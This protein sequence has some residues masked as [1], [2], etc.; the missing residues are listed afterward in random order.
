MQKV[1][2]L[3]EANAY[4]PCQVANLENGNA[5]FQ[6]PEYQ[7]SY[8]WS[9]ENIRRLM[10]D[11]FT[12]FE[13]LSHTTKA[14]AFTF[15][16]SLILVRDQ[17][18][19]PRFRGKS[20][21]IVDGQ[22]RLTT[23]A[24][25][26]CAL[27][28]ELRKR[29]EN[30]PSLQHWIVEW[31]DVEAAHIEAQLSDCVVGAQK[32]KGNHYFPFPRIVRAED[33]RSAD[34]AGEELRSGIAV[35][36]KEFAKFID[37][38]EIDFWEPDLGKTRE[39][40]KIHKNFKLIKSFCNS[41]SDVT[42]YE[43]LDCQMLDSGRFKFGGCIQL[44]DKNQDVFGDGES[45]ESSKTQSAI[46]EIQQNP[47]AHA[48]FRALMLA[49]YFNSCVAVTT[50]VTSDESAAF[51]I[52]D[53]LNTTGEP[54]TAIE[55][56]KPQVIRSENES[57]SHRYVGSDSEFA[58]QEIQEI[59]DKDYP[60]TKQRQGETKDLIVTFALYLK[61]EKVSKELSDQRRKLRQYFQEASVSEDGSSKFMK[62]LAGVTRYRSDYWVSANT[63]RINSYHADSAQADLVKLLSHFI[64]AMRTS[65]A[66][67][68][69]SRYW[70]IGRENNDFTSYIEV[71][72]AVS[73][74]L[75][76]RRAATGGTA[77]IDTCFRDMMDSGESSKKFG[78]CAGSKHQRELLDLTEFK[79]ALISKLDSTA[80]FGSKEEWV[81]HVIDIPIYT[82]ARPLSRFLLFSATHY[83]AVDIKNNK[84]LTR[85]GIAQSD[86]RVFLTNEKWESKQYVTV[87][88]VAPKAD[89]AKGWDEKIYA[90]AR[91]KHTLGNLVLLPTE[92]NARISNAPWSNKKT[93]FYTFTAREQQERESTLEKAE[94]DGMKFNKKTKEMILDGDRLSMLDGI[95]NVQDWDAEFIELRGRRLAS[96]AWD[97]LRPWLD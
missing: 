95:N 31:L 26:A 66:I 79:R 11:I 9:S 51:D 32:V 42:W 1:S 65:L 46:S 76:L 36:L 84:L 69:L 94:S 56:L 83:T 96:L 57:K 81:N 4:T 17:K 62:S 40:E 55:T 19:E 72:R 58:F 28:E 80:K 74:F 10:T 67:P 12:G 21:S 45:K 25:V 73:A 13:R 89:K 44:W 68:I 59:M 87:E 47:D 64:S 39:A 53:A 91:L 37:S 38:E 92:E 86:D 52:F 2:E 22:Q 3:F 29:R 6:I 60:E 16:G 88:H 43:D 90:N 24:L 33:T 71:L 97:Q 34:T 49:S 82:Q 8:D 77:G 23:L 70:I 54:L 93:F 48:Y 63:Q 61:G 41:L 20:F 5:G 35:F 14:G 27:I 30:L 78:L 85:E 15:L 18:Q 75:A 50:V 7:R